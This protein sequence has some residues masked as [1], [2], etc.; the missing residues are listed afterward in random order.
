MSL[1]FK[2]LVLVVCL[3]A[4]G[5]ARFSRAASRCFLS[6][7]FLLS[8]ADNDSLTEKNVNDLNVFHLSSKVAKYIDMQS[9]N[10]WR[11]DHHYR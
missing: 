10:A 1:S 11:M 5:G 7:L 4:G 2:L 3:V 8:N 9:V 6:I